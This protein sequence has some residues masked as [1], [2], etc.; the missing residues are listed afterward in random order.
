MTTKPQAPPKGTVR[1][2]VPP[3][4]QAAAPVTDPAKREII[5]ATATLLAP[6]D[7]DENLA[8]EFKRYIALKDKLLEDTDY[9]W[10][11]R[12]TMGDQEEMKSFKSRI[13]AETWADGLRKKGFE[14]ELE[15]KIKKS[16]C[17]KLGKAFGISD[18]P[19]EESLDRVVGSAY[20]KVRAEAPNGQ[21]KERT[22][23][24]DRAEKGKQKA[25]FDTIMATA[26]TRAADR[27]IMA[28]LGGETTA[29]EF[30]GVD[31]DALVT[32]TVAKD[33]ATP[34]PPPPQDDKTIKCPRCGG[35][36]SGTRGIL[37]MCPPCVQTP[38]CFICGDHVKATNDDQVPG[39]YCAKCEKLTPDEKERLVK[40]NQTFTDKKPAK[41]E[42]ERSQY[43][44]RLWAAAGALYGKDAERK[45][46]NTVKNKYG[47][48][49]TKDLTDDQFKE[50]AVG[51]ETY[52][53]A[54]GKL[55]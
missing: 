21:F 9:M 54:Q 48:E 7:T 14:T 38:G 43:N 55:K 25:P 27:A 16:G 47:K 12:W 53:K 44:K 33:A 39:A 19:I 2:V 45:V 8:A 6:V 1:T 13:K 36:Y 5:K 3:P 51:V 35:I 23:A 20:Y 30:E 41:Q 40:L 11:V 10:S 17:M 24:C 46:A 15:K 52:A 50:L 37:G 29:E 31:V 26:L 34:T 18:F 42:T 28:L 4:Q 32:R 49:S 22:G